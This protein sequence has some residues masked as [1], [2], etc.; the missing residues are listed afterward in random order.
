M[1]GLLLSLHLL[2]PLPAPA[3]EIT[4]Q[5][6][7]RFQLAL[8]EWLDDDDAAS[9]P[10]FAAL[11]A[12]GNRAAQ[13]MLGLIEVET[14]LH[15]PWLARLPRAERRALM[16]QPGGLSGRSWMAAAAA[17]TPLAA[18][19]VA[20][21]NAGGKVDP[22]TVRA[23]AA[24]GEDRAV[25]IALLAMSLGDKAGVGELAGEPFYPPS[26]RFLVWRDW[27]R[28]PAMAPRIAAEIA[29]LPP[30]DPQIA[31]QTGEPASPA[32]RAAWL[33]EARPLALMRAFC[34]AACP[35]DPPSCVAAAYRFH[36]NP[37]VQDF[38]SPI[39]TLVSSDAWHASA[40]GRASVLRHPCPRTTGCA[41]ISWPRSPRATP[42]SAPSSPPPPPASAADRP[43][44][45]T[46]DRRSR[47]RSAGRASGERSSTAFR[48]TT[49]A[50]C[51]ASVAMIPATM[52]SG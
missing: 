35:A 48:T 14:I 12:E 23:F 43:R 31:T 34:D 15:G 39:E 51:S 49:T 10:V 19:W 2:A 41:R 4:G 21:W 36:A 38:G 26:L 17:D 32:D 7:P 29:A 30:G 27:A 47:G 28:D 8:A 45:R 24:L 44:L 52:T 22:A 46:Q 1:R 5:T 40:R 6:D 9:L 18:A 37:E 33:A 20:L 16:R 25:R 11:A 3:D 42:A 13:V 50:A